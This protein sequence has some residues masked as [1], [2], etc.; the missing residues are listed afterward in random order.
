[1]PGRTSDTSLQETASSISIFFRLLFF[2]NDKSQKK[3]TRKKLM[4]I[5]ALIFFCL[6]FFINDK[7]QKKRTRKKLM[8]II[9]LIFFCLLFFHQGKN[10][11]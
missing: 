5:I 9:A 1:M 10:S 4:A 2:I 6:L 3:R 11:R 7:S 8:A